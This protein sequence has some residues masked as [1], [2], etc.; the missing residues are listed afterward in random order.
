[1]ECVNNQPLQILKF[2]RVICG[3]KVICK[4]KL[5]AVN[6]HV[7]YD[8]ITAG[9]NWKDDYWRVIH[10][11]CKGPTRLGKLRSITQPCDSFT[12]DLNCNDSRL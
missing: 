7:I 11:S 9:S 4:S 12:C 3:S 6:L 8:Q 10:R 2:V 1:M 5:N